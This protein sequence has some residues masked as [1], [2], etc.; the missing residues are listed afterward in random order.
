M[1]EPYP[2]NEQQRLATLNSYAILDSPPEAAFDRITRMAARIFNVPIALI[3]LVDTNRQWFKSCYGLDAQETSRDVAFCAH[4][5][6]GNEVLVIP[7]ATLDPRFANNPL[8]TGEP[9]IRFYAGAPLHTREGFNVGTLCII[10]TKPRAFTPEEREILADLSALVVD[11]MQ[12]RQSE[13][14]YYSLLSNSSDVFTV[15]SS[16]GRIC[17]E[18]PSVERVLGYHASELI[19]QSAF[20]F[21][22]P[23]DLAFVQGAFLA[24]I[25]NPITSPSVEFRW[26]KKDG[27]WRYLEAIGKNLLNDPHIK[28]IVVNSRDVSQR[29][30]LEAEHRKAGEALRRSEEKYRQLIQNLQEVFYFLDVKNEPFSPVWLS[31]QAEKITGRAPQE[32]MAQP[33]LWFSL[34]HPDDLPSFRQNIKEVIH[35]GQPHMTQYRLLHRDGEYRWIEDRAAPQCDQAGNI[36][37]VWGLARDITH[38]KRAENALRE[39]EERFKGAFTLSATG[40]ALVAPDGRWL[41]VNQALCDMVGYSENELLRMDFQAITH[42]DDLYSDLEFVQEMLDGRRATYQMEKRYIHRNG[43]LVWALLSVALMRDSNGQ[44]LN[45]I[46]QVQ[47]IT[48]RK[49]AEKALRDSELRKTAILET[50]LDCIISI[51][52]QGCIVEWNPAAEA[53]FGYK[54]QEVLGQQM[55]NVLIPPHLRESHHQGMARYMASGENV[56]LGQ[57]LELPAIRKDGLEILVEMA[58]NRIPVEGPPQFTAYLRDITGRKRDEAALLKAKEEAEREREN[59]QRA[60]LAKSQFLSRMSHELRTPLN[61]ILG[62]GQLLEI[63]SLCEPDHQSVHQIMKA[64]RHLLDL[65]NEVL[66]ISRIESGNLAISLEPVSVREVCLDTLDLVKPMAAQRVISL[67]T[68]LHEEQAEYISADRQRIK[69]VLLNLLSNA[70]KYNR[71]GG[72]VSLRVVPAL[73]GRLRI[74]V[75]DTGRGI[76]PEKMNRLFTPFDRL[77]AEASGIEGTGI[78]LTLSRRLMEA[79]GGTLGVESEMGKGTT[80]W[81]DLPRAVNPLSYGAPSTQVAYETT[82]APISTRWIVLYIEDNLLNLELIQRILAQR[83]AIKLLSSMQGGLGIELAQ[84]HR[85]DLILLDL[86]LPEMSGEDVLR[87][88]RDD[89]QTRDIPIVVISADATPGQIERLLQAGANDYVTKPFDMHELLRIMDQNFAKS[90]NLLSAKDSGM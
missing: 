24:L 78:G 17:Y 1:K 66:D 14:G 58:V 41:R 79:M 27:S 45:F 47:D 3:S 72:C 2:V 49:N 83:P 21:I 33:E 37:G 36:C 46:S 70:V 43:H 59:A 12:L 23:D 87:Q 6:L 64:G 65:I 55:A 76:P 19:G 61:A 68:N 90:Q 51:D 82:T 30:Q 48:E 22:H 11:E 42:P 26:R 38:R 10:D 62:F 75:T 25:Q 29:K 8:V 32:F 71:D 63:S 77:D 15:L 69:Q 5:I 86:H 4:A 16:E 35:S 67:E 34:V 81:I 60:N 85:P 56:I 7:D 74:N 28:G 73:N 39:S 88:L 53:V 44:P 52:H 50:A 9:H 89:P 54:Q 18:S 20:E 40:M 31:A 84:R 80:F 13:R 57:R